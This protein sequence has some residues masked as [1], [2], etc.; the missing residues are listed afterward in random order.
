MAALQPDPRILLELATATMP[1]GKYSG[2]LLVRIPE[3]YFLWFQERGFPG[4]KLGEQM[5]MMLEIKVNGLE[6]LIYKVA[7][8][9]DP[10]GGD[11]G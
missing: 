4:G 6:P 9:A 10:L 5:K 2:R 1:F 7:R 8:L 11:F 3:S